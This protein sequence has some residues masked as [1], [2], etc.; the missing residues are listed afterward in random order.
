MRRHIH[1]VRDL[2]I[3]VVDFFYPVFKPFMNLQTFRY[4]ACGGLNT[5]V[6]FLSWY[7]IF[8]FILR[9]QNLSLYFFEIKPYSGALFIS[10]FIS[11]PFGFFLM[12]YVVFTDSQLRGKVQIVRYFMLYLINLV[13]NY[14]LLKLFVEIIHIYPTFAQVITTILLIVFSYLFQR[15]FTFKATP[16]EEISQGD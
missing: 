5:L 4:A 10:F 13:L 15:H 7:I 9:E 11:F 3:P 16:L 12:K 2:V 1:N 8:K 14:A 6:G